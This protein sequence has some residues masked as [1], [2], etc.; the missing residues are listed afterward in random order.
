M[1][2]NDDLELRAAV[3][4]KRVLQKFWMEVRAVE[5]ARSLRLL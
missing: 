1:H 4:A 5:S 3:A 2:A